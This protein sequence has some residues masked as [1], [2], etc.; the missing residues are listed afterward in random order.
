MMTKELHSN[1]AYKEMEPAVNCRKGAPPSVAS[2]N[3][4][5]FLCR[6]LKA[7]TEV[8]PK[9][10]VSSTPP[11]RRPVSETPTT[12][13]LPR[14]PADHNGVKFTFLTRFF[15]VV[16]SLRA[17]SARPRTTKQTCRALCAPRREDPWHLSARPTPHT[18]S[19]QIHPPHLHTHR[20]RIGPDRRAWFEVFF[21][22]KS[23]RRMTLSICAFQ[24][25]TLIVRFLHFFIKLTLT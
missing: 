17:S 24:N 21:I 4:T 16:S 2:M 13:P 23:A 1:T 14:R 5:T 22:M 6:L 25:T 9:A 18:R 12:Y 20:P 7:P 8:G 10:L 11:P 15:A 19:Q 3:S